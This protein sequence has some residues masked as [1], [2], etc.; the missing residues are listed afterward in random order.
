MLVFPPFDMYLSLIA[1]TMFC[2]A[3]KVL[4]PVEQPKSAIHIG[5]GEIEMAL[6]SKWLAK[7]KLNVKS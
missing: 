2:I 4:G 3:M 1:S 7:Y 6:M 5:F